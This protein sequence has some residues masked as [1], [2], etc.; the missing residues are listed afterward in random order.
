MKNK[1][2]IIDSDSLNLSQLGNILY[3]IGNGI[4]R[5]AK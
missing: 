4:T 2:K 3:V 1:F 5:H